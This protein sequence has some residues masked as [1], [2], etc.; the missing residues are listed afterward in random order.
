MFSRKLTSAALAACLAL[1]FPCRNWGNQPRL[2]AD[3]IAYDHEAG[4]VRA[5]GARLHYEGTLLT[6]NE[7][8][9]NQPSRTASAKG[10]VTITSPD[11]RVVGD[12]AFYDVEERS[13][14][15]QD[16]RFGQPP[17]HAE[18][19]DI[20]AG[21]S[22]VELEDAVLYFGEPSPMALNLRARRVRYVPDERVKA[23]N[24]TI[25]IGR[26]PVF[27]VPAFTRRLGGLATE[28]TA[29]AGYSGNLGA[30]AYLATRT[31]IFPGLSVGPELGYYGRRGFLAGPGL[32]YRARGTEHWMEG[33]LSSGYIRDRGDTGLDR[34][35]RPIDEDRYFAEWLHKQRAG[36]N[37]ELTAQANLWSDSEVTRDFRPRLFR[38]N[39]FP[40]NF[41][42]AAY[43]GEGHVV[44]LF[45]RVSPHNFQ[46][47]Q[48]RL[49]EVRF[50]LLPRRAGDYFYH[51]LQASAAALR[52]E[53]PLAENV[54]SDRLDLYYGV[55]WPIVATDWL[56]VTPKTGARLTHYQR[57]E[58]GRDHYTRALGEIGLD[59]EMN[60][61]S[62]YDYRNEL[63][64]IDGVRHLVKPRV[65]Y[66]YIPGA[67]R[68]ARFIP[69]VDRQTFTTELEP[70]DLGRIRHID[71]LDEV[72][73][74]RYGADNIF[75][76]R[77]ASY[78]S[79]D[80][81]ALFIANDLRFSR[82]PGEEFVSD[83]HARL[84]FTPV[85]WLRLD[86][87]NRLSPHEPEVQEVSA[88]LTLTDARFW[89]LRLGSEYLPELIEQ[90]S[91]FYSLR[92][93]ETYGA[94]VDLRYDAIRDSFSRQ[95]Y[96]VIQN[97]HN[98]WEVRYQ[99]TFRTGT[100]REA[101]TGFGISF[102]YLSL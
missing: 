49:P 22:L 84:A 26:V 53:N 59:A 42:E 21:Q 18:A 60:A 57:A 51:Q 25:R 41:F 5:R 95:T 6:A 96:S 100:E 9:Y 89:A 97:I 12:E 11:L 82:Q 50:D 99:V 30:F 47:V 23:E 40:D 17:F 93:N 1:A 16:L 81:L 98:T 102:S 45:S 66:R 86:A 74:L 19:G 62:V 39:Q 68:G 29:D 94:S 63:W 92:L 85:Y 14:S 87:R 75:Q 69:E 32:S 55:N 70:I 64:R 27:Y 90:Y 8:L 67:D 56:T 7:V 78:G 72:H 91:M 31:P 48:E 76:T 101:S 2:D 33:G 36:E 80:L 37:L 15:G 35:E 4:G 43:L 38:D 10:S 24:V 44:S 61:F 34:L 83:I 88:D 3:D 52:E 58:E 77:H 71:D 65:E 13:A 54:R 73:T 79:R 28:A 20:T 46:I